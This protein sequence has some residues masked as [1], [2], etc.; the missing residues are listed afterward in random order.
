MKEA[1]Q[2]PLDLAHRPAY[3]REDFWVSSSNQEAIA[4]VDKW[5]D[6]PS[7]GVIIVGPE[8][9]GKTHLGHVWQQKSS[10]RDAASLQKQEG[11]YPPA[12]IFDDVDV[13][14]NSPEN[15]A[16]IFHLINQLKESGG[17][18]LMTASLPP[19]AWKV[20]LPDLL[21]RLNAL[22]L[23]ILAPPDENL[24]SVLLAK[25]F[26][27]RQIAVGEDVI[28]FIVMRVDRSFAAL[29]AI[30][31]K[32]DT[33]AMAKKKAITIPLIREILAEQGV[34]L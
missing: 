1:Q 27:D 25:M 28:R 9:S 29:R 22:P 20:R 19:S 14:L 13:F 33:R 21:S 17:K 12:V 18:F 31:E 8:A 2:L 7:T 5:P 4:W 6:W 10:A 30:V 3:G 15:E 34:E 11:I 24:S 16:F 26:S 23:V 32:V